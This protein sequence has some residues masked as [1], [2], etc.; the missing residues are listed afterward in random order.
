MMNHRCINII[1]FQFVRNAP[2]P[3]LEA[4]GLPYALVRQFP[5]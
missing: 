3:K 4:M 2:M 1:D 5:K